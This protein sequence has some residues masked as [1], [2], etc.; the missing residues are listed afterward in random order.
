[1]SQS[2][3]RCDRSFSLADKAVFCPY[4]GTSMVGTSD[5][6][7]RIQ[8]SVGS[9]GM[10]TI[11]E[12]YWEMA[13]M[14]LGRAMRALTKKSVPRTSR[15][16]FSFDEWL[17]GLR[18]CQS[19]N[20]M[21]TR[22]VDYLGKLRVALCEG[23]ANEEAIDVDA[24]IDGINSICKQ[25]AEAVSGSSKIWHLP[26]TAYDPDETEE[27]KQNPPK[28][29]VMALLDALE[30]ALPCLQR[31]VAE[32]GTY[33][34]FADTKSSF[35]ENSEITAA[36]LHRTSKSIEQLAKKD[37]DPLFGE[38][39][40]EFILV[41]WK[42]FALLSQCANVF[43]RA[44]W[45]DQAEEAK[46]EAIRRHLDEWAGILNHALDR[47]YATNEIDMMI[48]FQD[49]DSVAKSVFQDEDDE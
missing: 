49:I 10:R 18:K 23:K 47:T 6:I 35:G 33:V 17:V 48:V 19:N 21:V 43:I 12:K 4:C 26:E 7:S 1:M 3:T 37:Y 36:K 28:E 41:L 29:A 38:A 14:A 13:Q 25:L 32:N 45:I 22:C 5:V 16:R 11:Q 27:E 31:V 20:E 24:V 2:C 46:R 39:Y 30:A 8:V 9:N 15:V 40:D 42:G 44:Q 34:A